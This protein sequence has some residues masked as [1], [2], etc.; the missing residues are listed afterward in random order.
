MTTVRVLGREK[1]T[2]LMAANLAQC[3]VMRDSDIKKKKKIDAAYK[4]NENKYTYLIQ[5]QENLIVA[6]AILAVPYL[7]KKNETRTT[8]KVSV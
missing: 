6:L 7:I 2:V 5:S 1:N 4:G 3:F 8:I